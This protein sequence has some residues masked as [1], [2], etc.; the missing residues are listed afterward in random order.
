MHLG[1]LLG[2]WQERGAP[3]LPHGV[4]YPYVISYAIHY[5]IIASGQK[6]LLSTVQHDSHWLSCVVQACSTEDPAVHC[7]HSTI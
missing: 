7:A 3:R 5:T 2:Y 4:V 6:F 1:E